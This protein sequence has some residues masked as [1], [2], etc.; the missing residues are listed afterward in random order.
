[1]RLPS[2]FLTDISGEPGLAGAIA[3]VDLDVRCPHCA[4]STTIEVGA[5]ARLAQRSG[6]FPDSVCQRCG[7]MGLGAGAAAALAHLD[8]ALQPLAEEP[9]AYL[10]TRPTAPLSH[11]SGPESFGRYELVAPL[12]AGGMAEVFLARQSGAAGFRKLVVMK[13]ILPA[14]CADQ[15]FVRSFLAEAHLAARLHHPNI[16]QILDLGEV[17]GR[18]FICL[19]YVRG[20]DLSVI[21]RACA[22]AGRVPPLEVAVYIAR[23]V[24]AAL[25]AVHACPGADGQPLG[26]V[27]GDISASNV[28]ISQD[29]HVKLTDFGIARALAGSVA[30][31][32]A[33][34][35]KLAYLAP[36]Q[37]SGKETVDQRADVFAAGVL[38]H[39]LVTLRPP[40]VRRAGSMTAA[41]V[42][43][44]QPPALS[45]KGTPPALDAIVE[46]A[47][48]NDLRRRYRS[49]AAMRA[50]LD[51]LMNGGGLRASASDLELFL[52]ALPLDRAAVAASGSTPSDTRRETTHP[53]QIV[54]RPRLQ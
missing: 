51:A 6:T 40:Y 17:R 8:V 50:D 32:Q 41:S 46:R 5:I 10:A 27:H 42:K 44:E 24:C 3:T 26:I 52:H 7:H 37:I 4:E 48:V 9:R 18:Y 1:M 19:E 31:S 13:R 33:T 25:T 43:R 11:G 38:L 35:G 28:L 16:V 47:L 34:R 21:L 15:R 12:A 39:E 2:R 30:P 22:D 54:R 45:R 23:E 49:G 20:W 36:E 29:G 14:L 53:T